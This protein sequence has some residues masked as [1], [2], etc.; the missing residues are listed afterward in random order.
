MKY[1]AIIDSEELEGFSGFS[2]NNPRMFVHKGQR[3][4]EI[5][6]IPI[7]HKATNRDIQTKGGR[8]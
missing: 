5:E 8:E 7:S 3:M 6:F 1:M 2:E 4:K